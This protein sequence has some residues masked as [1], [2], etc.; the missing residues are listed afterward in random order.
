VARNSSIEGPS[1]GSAEDR[2]VDIDLARGLAVFGMYAAHVGGD[3]IPDDLGLIGNLM[4]LPLGRSSALFAVL[5]GF[6][7]ILITGR[8]ARKS[9]EAGRQAVARVAIRALVLL[10]IGSILTR[11]GTGIAVILKT[12]GICFLLVLPLYRRSAQQLG[13]LAAGTA[14]VLPQ[15]RF[16]LK[17]F[18]PEGSLNPVFDFMVHGA[19]PAMTWVPFVIAGMAIARLSLNTQAMHWRLGLEGVAL[20]VLGYGGSWLAL[21]LLPV[22]AVF[23]EPLDS[24]WYLDSPWSLLVAAPHSETTFSILGNTGCA[25][26]VLAACWLA[27]D[28][29]PRLRKMFRPVVAVGSMSLTV[30]V[31]HIVGIAYLLRVMGID[32]AGEDGSLSMLLGFVVATSTFAVLWLRAFQRGPMEVL[33]GRITDLARHIL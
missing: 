6:S 32:S 30:Y 22:P 1:D 19:Y 4:E 24:W 29:L 33:M 2:L 3:P 9:G 26:I 8:K 20:A 25:M 16:L 10:A 15:M 11:L 12:Y 17:L 7:I 28:S 21:R 23:R 18:G 14:L 5:A 31:L 13:L 27:M